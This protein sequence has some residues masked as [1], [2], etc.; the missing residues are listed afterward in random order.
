MQRAE[1]MELSQP[2]E[3][4]IFPRALLVGPASKQDGLGLS[5]WLYCVL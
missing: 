2:R 3:T 4:L 1:D 5:A